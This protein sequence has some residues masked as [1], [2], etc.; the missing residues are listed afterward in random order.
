MLAKQGS[1]GQDTAAPKKQN[2]ITCDKGCK[3]RFELP[4]TPEQL[5]SMPAGIYKGQDVTAYYFICPHCGKEYITYC[6]TAETRRLTDK[7]KKLQEKRRA[8]LAT[9]GDPK[10]PK[11]NPKQTE[12]VNKEAGQLMKREKKLMR[13]M[14]ELQAVMRDYLGLAR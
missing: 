7:Y 10:A 11:L 14:R 6:E 12:K 9:L 2:Q 8:L 13:Q 4:Q 5:R 1:E 3:K